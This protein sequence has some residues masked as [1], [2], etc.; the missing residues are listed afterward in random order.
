M[1][2]AYSFWYKTS[3]VT[4]LMHIPRAV[5]DA[6]LGKNSK[7]SPI[8]EYVYSVGV[9]PHACAIIEVVR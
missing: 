3:W 7:I 8:K 4:Y 1:N 6:K 5:Y 9:P 2:V